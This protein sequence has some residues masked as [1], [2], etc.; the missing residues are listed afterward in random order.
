[1]NANISPALPADLSQHPGY[2]RV[3]QP[4]KLS[5]GFIMPLE[6]YPDSPFPTLAEHGRLARLA[7]EAGFAALW[8]RDVPF[9]DPRFGDTGQMLDPMV[10][11]GYLA[12]Q[13]RN[14]ALG[15]AG[16]VL[17][18]R[19]PIIVAKQAASVDVL[20]DQRLVLGLS[21]GDRPTEYP[22]FAADFDNRAERYREGIGLIRTLT[23]ESFPVGRTRHYGT[24]RG[25]L[26]LIPKPVG[27]RLPMVVVGR[28][29]QDMH[30]IAKHTDGWIGHLSDF[31]CLHH[32]LDDWRKAGE[33]L[34]FKPYGYG[35]FFDLAEN[36][37]APLH[38]IGNRFSVGRNALID[39]WSRQQEQGVSHVA[40]NLKPIRRPAEEVIREL[41]EYVLPHFAD[42]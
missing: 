20:S 22:A 40:L 3:F 15:T 33:G 19:D 29:R 38:Y 39:L 32:L 28:A 4:G 11:L 16:I 7:D 35:S 23:E 25:N 14:I 24:F 17:P 13:T 31:G 10:Y 9:F 30:W 5:I 21:T 27:P 36:P 34:G 37:D 12:S 18:L 6:S 41:A 1:M 2:S 8:M 42:Q 26:D